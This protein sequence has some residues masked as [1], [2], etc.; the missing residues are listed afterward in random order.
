MHKIPESLLMLD[1]A[2]DLLHTIDEGGGGRSA[3]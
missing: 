3:V 2:V 1:V